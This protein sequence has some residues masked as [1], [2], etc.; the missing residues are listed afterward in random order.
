MREGQDMEHILRH[1]PG[2]LIGLALVAAWLSATGVWASETQQ[3]PS[4]SASTLDFANGLYARRMYAPAISEYQK[5]LKENPQSP[6]TASARF[7]LADSHYFMKDYAATADLFEQFVR[8]FPEDKR[9]WV[10]RFRVGASR[11]RLEDWQA[12][13]RAFFKLTQQAPDPT[14]QGGSFFYLAKIYQARGKP[15]QAAAVYRKVMTDYP[16]TEYAALSAVALG[17]HYLQRK[18][19]AEAIRALGEAADR[20]EPAEIAQEARFKIAE[21]LYGQNDPVAARAHYKK[22]LDTLSAQEASGR[23]QRDQEL[24]D[25]TLTGVFYCDHKAGAL[26]RARETY[27]AYEP[28][29]RQSKRQDEVDFL[30][31]D[32]AADQGQDALALVHLERVL[33][34]AD[35]D[36]TF[37][38][39]ATFKKAEILRKSGQREQ[40]LSQ[41]QA[42]IDSQ[43]K[44]S[45]R[46]H[47]EKARIADES[48]EFAQALAAYQAVV[49]A[50]SDVYARP[51]WVRLGFLQMQM[52]DPKSARQSFLKFLEKYPDDENVPRVLLE[53]VQIDLDAKQHESAQSYAARFVQDFPDNPMA[54]IAY[55]KLGMALMGQ[56]KF[57]AASI[58]FGRVVQVFETSPL[59]PEALYGAAVSADRGGLSAESIIFYEQF[60]SRFPHHAL[61]KEAY[62]RGG[63]LYFQTEDYTRASALYQD[64]LLNRP[65]IEVNPEIAFWLLRY[66]LENARYEP[67]RAVLD[68]L[69]ERFRVSDLTHEI[70]FF[71]GECALGVKD[72]A[73]AASRYRQSLAASPEGT[74]APHAHLGLGIA[75]GAQHQ[76]AEAEEHLNETLRFDQELALNVRARF[77]LARLR[78]NAGDPL[79]AA[80]AYM[81]VA[82]LYDDAKYSPKALYEASR[83]FAQAQL[84]DEAAKAVAELKT[85]YPDSEWAQKA[86]TP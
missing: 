53:M 41:L 11:L 73:L 5:F 40:A 16:Q 84:A 33:S 79:E 2:K 76:V 75:L 78:L 47:F 77:E 42:I 37:R 67:A 39:Q 72:A 35:A 81:L 43:S 23:S 60:I 45:A 46:A 65:D 20:R 34:R 8:D 3:A 58:A 66:L 17:E 22:L 24:L 26:D 1:H 4:P 9:V 62:L 86:S 63:Q 59:L 21:I 55:Y 10:A 80:K 57:Q 74:F 7:R 69:S 83:C 27:A 49:D 82:I 19:P 13:G 51:A 54:D 31:G 12:A 14:V 68:R 38:E 56:Q 50:Q 32:L 18:R 52:A 85:R 70:E 61:F 28:L 30:V 44:Q 71:R 15:A 36:P 25:K 48:Q 6:Q 64:I 29:I